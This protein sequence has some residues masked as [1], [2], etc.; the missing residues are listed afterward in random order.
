MYD[1]TMPKLSDSMETGKIIRWHVQK[2]SEVHEG[3]VLAEVE[4]DK[5]VMELEC[6][7]D[8]VIVEILRGDNE[9][10][11]VGEVIA[12]IGPKGA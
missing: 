9:E 4:S 5:A 11:P 2:G 6:F 10:A 3:D 1:V 8:G 7:H 12:R